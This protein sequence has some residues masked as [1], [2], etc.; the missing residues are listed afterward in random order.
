MNPQ[1]F[2]YL[3]ALF[4][5][6]CA[7]TFVLYA[8]H[9]GDPAPGADLRAY[10]AV[11][12]PWHQVLLAVCVAQ[13][14]LASV[15]FGATLMSARGAGAGLLVATIGLNADIVHAASEGFVFPALTAVMDDAG[16]RGVVAAFQGSPPM[17]AMSIAGMALTAIGLLMLAA[18]KE[19]ARLARVLALIAVVLLPAPMLF[20]RAFDAF[21]LAAY[22][23]LSLAALHF[24]AQ[25]PKWAWA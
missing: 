12:A 19:N 11:A 10:L 7:A 15:W 8:A 17:I 24:T 18:Q 13:L 5:A 21:A 3:N 25:R 20:S 22:A 9:P 14:I 23:A 4:I 6:S 1:F 2:R 16:V